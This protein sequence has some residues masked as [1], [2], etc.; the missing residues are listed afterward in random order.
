MSVY[1]S[2]CVRMCRR[3]QI[4]KKESLQIHSRG[5][6]D[7]EYVATER[8]PVSHGVFS[9]EKIRRFPQPQD[10]PSAPRDVRDNRR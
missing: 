2:M 7:D 8:G 9:N 1:V 6:D 5:D 4:K 3:L 10:V